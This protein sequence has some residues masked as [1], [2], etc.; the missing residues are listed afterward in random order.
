MSL[1]TDLVAAGCVIDSHYADLYVKV[2]Y[3][4]TQILARFPECGC[5]TFLSPLDGAA[6]YEIPFQ[7]D[8]YWQER[9]Q[10]LAHLEPTECD[11]VCRIVHEA[12]SECRHGKTRGKR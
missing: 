1:Y 2:S 8:P 6:W 4:S 9:S 3:E 11:D 12:G 10:V 7:F 5:T